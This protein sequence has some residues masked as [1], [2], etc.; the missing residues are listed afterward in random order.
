MP[1]D[2]KAALEQIA[3]RDLVVYG[4][5]WCPDCTRLERLLERER[6]AH[7]TID[8]ETDPAAKAKL[9]RETGKRAIPYILVDGI[10]WVR[11]YHKELPGRLN[12]DVL[13]Q[14]LA[15]APRGPMKEKGN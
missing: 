9:V 12:L 3:G 1:D 5:D 10:F 6:I 13:L 7:R 11:G 14:E 8:I 15:Q 2:R 4:A